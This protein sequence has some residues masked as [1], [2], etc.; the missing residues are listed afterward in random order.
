M[1]LDPQVQAL[2]KQLEALNLPPLNSLPPEE[3]R[4]VMRQRRELTAGEPIPVGRVED[5]AI[6]GPDDAI[7]VRI[8]WPEANAQAG[9]GPLPV[10]V[11]FHGGGW[12]LGDL[13]SH[14]NHCRV[15]CRDAGCLVVSVDYRLAPEHPFPAA[16]EDAYAATAWVAA[17]A[18]SLGGDP[19][20]LAVGGDSAGGNLAAVVCLM[21]RDRGGPPIR[22]QL[23]IYPVTDHD[24]D[25]ASYRANADGLF[26]TREAMAWFWDHYVPDRGERENPYVSP[27]RAPDLSGLPPALVIT[28]EY[29]PLR[30]EG[31]AYAE[32]L[33][34]AGVPVELVE[35]PG[36]IHGFV[37]M[38]AQLSGGQAAVELE[39]RALRAALGAP[40]AA[41]P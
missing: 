3:A 1:P 9:S 14:D 5:R 8:Y 12:V 37:N 16:A 29:D 39:A 10:L 36:Q 20:R 35:Y 27:L 30:D 11:Y 2:L 34:A 6:P 13:E 24:L 25:T 7:P 26:L 33:R 28:A 19:A 23:L 4:S 15:L 38:F 22:F 41:T 17:Q 21:A 32:R 40:A 31:N 18:A